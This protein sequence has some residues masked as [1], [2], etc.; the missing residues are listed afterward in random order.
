MPV[1]MPVDRHRLAKRVFAFTMCVWAV[2][3]AV[4]GTT[5]AP[6][7]AAFSA[8]GRLTASGQAGDVYVDRHGDFAPAFAGTVCRDGCRILTPYVSPPLVLPVLAVA[9]GPSLDAAAIGFRAG[10][11]LCL[12]AAMVLLWRRLAPSSPAR[13]LALAVAAVALTP[14][15][16]QTI[17]FG[18]TTPAVMLGGAVSL[19]NARRAWVGAGLGALVGLLTAVKVFPL[20]QLVV[21]WRRQRR[22]VA[23]GGLATLATLTAV[24]TVQLPSSIVGAFVDGSAGANHLF[25]NTS[26]SSA[27]VG[28]SDRVLGGQWPAWVF[29]AAVLVSLV[30]ARKRLRG[31]PDDVIW[32]VAPFVALAFFPVLWAHYLLVAFLALAVCVEHR[33]LH[34]RWLVGAA[35]ATVPAAALVFPASTERQ[36][37]AGASLTV[38]ALLACGVA[39]AVAVARAPNAGRPS[40]RQVG[41]ACPSPPPAPRR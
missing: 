22:P 23:A 18:Q 31:L 27:L 26:A 29:R 13:A 10:G 2:F 25:A 19:S 7:A 5:E 17:A 21:A 12:V 20:T 15:A 36:R 41:A 28:V 35:L 9:G 40:G 4:L 8:A 34:W 24:A 11:T 1:D 32:A 39:V 38:L 6:D 33:L 3:P 16:Y 37:A 14:L 30:V